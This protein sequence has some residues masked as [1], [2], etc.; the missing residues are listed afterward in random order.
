MQSVEQ[1]NVKSLDS[2]YPVHVLV[3]CRIR[4]DPRS[5]CM[6][7]YPLWEL[8]AHVVQKSFKTDPVQVSDAR[9]HPTEKPEGV[10]VDHKKTIS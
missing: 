3:S 6:R 2:K 4:M 7:L 8:N 5:E 9:N 1:W 10:G